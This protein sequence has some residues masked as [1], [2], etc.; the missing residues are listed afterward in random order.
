M[1]FDP[2]PLKPVTAPATPN[3]Y[4]APKPVSGVNGGGEGGPVE[5]TWADI[6]GKPAYIGA[7]STAQAACN[8]ILAAPIA[9]THE[10]DA[11]KADAISPG[12]A[13]D[14]QGLLEELA[15]RITAL[16]EAE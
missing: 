16:E 4:F 5:V 2:L 12:T 15:A 13:T 7:G 14:V 6:D 8:A 11:V 9:H 3:A 1:S 10:A